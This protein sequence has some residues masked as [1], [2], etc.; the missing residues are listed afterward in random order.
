MAAEIP[1]YEPSS[2]VAGDTV[3][4]TRSLS[5]YSAADGWSLSYAIRGVAAVDIDA[6]VDTDGIGF[7]VTLTA[8]E[9]AKLA[10]GQYQL[11]GYVFSDDDPPEQYTVFGPV[12]IT[13]LPNVADAAA[14]DLVEPEE[15]E[16]A[17]INAQIQ[18]LLATDNESYSIGQRAAT[19]RKLGELYQARGIVIARLGRKRGQRVPSREVVF[20]AA[21]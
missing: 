20:N 2:F 15:K 18:T 9:S 4:W 7:A 1:T 21:R 16:L 6:T 8:A 13:V 11:V 3:K 12:S 17:L 14:G 10:A 5:D 19:K